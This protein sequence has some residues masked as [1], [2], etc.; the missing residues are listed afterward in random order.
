MSLSECQD[1]IPR[2]AIAWMDSLPMTGHPAGT[3]LT[4]HTR[5]RG[6]GGLP[7][8]WQAAVQRRDDVRLWGPVTGHPMG[9]PLTDHTSYVKAVAFSLDLASA[10]TEGTVR[11][12]QL[13]SACPSW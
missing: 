4:G 8:G 6:G 2:L 10:S 7:F 12:R 3:N 1:L 5:P 11:L 13:S 9:A